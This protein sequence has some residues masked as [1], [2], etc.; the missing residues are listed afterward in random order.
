MVFIPGGKMM[1]GTSAADGRDGESPTQA[2][3]LQPFQMDKYPVTNSD[4]RYLSLQ[5]LTQ[6]LVSSLPSP[7][8]F[9]GTYDA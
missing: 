1:M 3:T 5:I 8:F 9:L 7:F 6:N 4:F 2:V